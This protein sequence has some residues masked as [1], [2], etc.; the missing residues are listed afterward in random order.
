M[1]CEGLFSGKNKKITLSCRLLNLLHSMLWVNIRTPH[2]RYF[3]F[4]YL[5]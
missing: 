5:E 2:S 3:E 1:K 4:A